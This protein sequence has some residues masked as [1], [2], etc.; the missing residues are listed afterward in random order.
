MRCDH[1]RPD[2]PGGGNPRKGNTS[3]TQVKNYGNDRYS[4]KLEFDHYQDGIQYQGLDKLNLNNIILDNTYMKDY[5][6]YRMMQEFGVDAPLCSYAYITVNGE[7]W[8]LYL[9]VE[10]VEE[11]FPER[12]YG[13]G[14]GELYKP[15]SVMSMGDG[16]VG[17]DVELPADFD[18]S[19]LTPPNGQKAGEDRQTDSAQTQAEQGISQG[20]SRY[21]RLESGGNASSHAPGRTAGGNGRI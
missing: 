5:L 18:F 8:G 12:N 9:A 16:E 1:R 17:G 14:S 21:G 15:D 19:H 4:F 13:D 10:G 20:T 2:S 7:E 11:S 3:L 6:S